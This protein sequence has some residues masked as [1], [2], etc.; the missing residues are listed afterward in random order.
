MNSPADVTPASCEALHPRCT[1]RPPRIGEGGDSDPYRQIN[2][3]RA[4]SED[5]ELLRRIRSL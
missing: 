5:R 1:P 3:R 4:A 2:E